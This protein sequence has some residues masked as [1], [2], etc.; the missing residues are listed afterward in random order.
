MGP[1]DLKGSGG[2]GGRATGVRGDERGKR[3]GASGQIKIAEQR[4]AV[5]GGVG[6]PAAGLDRLRCRHF[7]SFPGFESARTNGGW[8]TY[9]FSCLA[10]DGAAHSVRSPPN[11]T[12][13]CRGLVTLRMAGSGHARIRLGRGWGGG[14]AILSQLAHRNLSALPPS[15]AL[16]HKE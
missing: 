7:V 3:P 12:P 11:Q 16:P 8:P 15:P 1:R 10:H 6:D 4:Y 5:M 9:V 2:E 14:R 13:A